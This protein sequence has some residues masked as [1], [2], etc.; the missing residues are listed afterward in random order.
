[1]HPAA[2][3][4]VY[5]QYEVIVVLIVGVYA[6]INANARHTRKKIVNKKYKGKGNFII[7]CHR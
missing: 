1:M 5:R 4:N 2:Y 6:S 3:P 7:I